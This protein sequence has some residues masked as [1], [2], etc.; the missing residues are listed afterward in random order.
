MDNNDPVDI[1]ANLGI[2]ALRFYGEAP[3][4]GGGGP[5]GVILLGVVATCVIA[6]RASPAENNWRERVAVL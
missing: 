5:V 4:G 6:V 3:Y 2:P 1:A